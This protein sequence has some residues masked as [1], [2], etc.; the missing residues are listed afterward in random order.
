MT[1][2]GAPREALEQLLES[3]VERARIARSK[4]P[5]RTCADTCCRIAE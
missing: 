2:Q 4:Y 1:A 5:H 3:A